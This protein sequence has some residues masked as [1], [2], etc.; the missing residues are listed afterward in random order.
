MNYSRTSPQQPSWGQTKVATVES[1]KQESLYRLFAKKVANI[2][3]W[4]LWREE[5]ISG[6]ST[7][8]PLSPNIHIQILQT[9]LYKF[10]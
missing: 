6:S 3:R 8:N 5:P 4:L 7:V 1:F 2:E 9:D 10:P